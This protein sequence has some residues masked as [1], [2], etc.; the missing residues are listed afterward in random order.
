M[1]ELKCPKC[2]NAFT[3]D[4]ADYAFIL[5][6]VKTSEFNAEV[7]K[8]LK[9]L[10]AGEAAQRELALSEQKAEMKTALDAKEREI[11]SLKLAL[12]SKESEAK[13][14]E[15]QKKLEV[16]QAVARKEDEIIRLKAEIDGKDKAH[17]VDLVKNQMQQQQ[18]LADKDA[19]IANLKAG[20]ESR[21]KMAD[22]QIAFYKDMKAR[23]STKMTGEALEVHCSTEYER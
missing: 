1:K 12:Q 21:L 17:Q 19:E 13:S 11:A 23:L 22:E 20:Y 4:E 6:Q 9:E 3:V 2:G 14:A 8:R 15:L 7:E 5:Q 16:Q 18:A 10:Q